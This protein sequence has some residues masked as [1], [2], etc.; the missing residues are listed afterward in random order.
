MNDSPSATT[1]PVPTWLR[2]GLSCCT[3]EPKFEPV[4]TTFPSL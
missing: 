1:V 3:A 4:C 2:N